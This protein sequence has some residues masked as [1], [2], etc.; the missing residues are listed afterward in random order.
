MKYSDH[1][2]LWNKSCK[3]IQAIWA[4]K[5]LYG[6]AERERI[7]MMKLEKENGKK[8]GLQ[9]RGENI[10]TERE[11]S[12]RGKCQRKRLNINRVRK[13]KWEKNNWKERRGGEV[14]WER[15]RQIKLSGGVER[16]SDWERW[17]EW[18]NQYAW[19]FFTW[20][21]ATDRGPVQSQIAKEPCWRV[22]HT[23]T[24]THAKTHIHAYLSPGIS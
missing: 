11:F 17:R 7:K 12:D 15:D 10:K 5:S 13:T 3:A 20:S 2:K 16:D 22:S 8:K 21:T 9:W 18:V 1:S 19:A 23:D 6:D 4:M 14:K 24:N